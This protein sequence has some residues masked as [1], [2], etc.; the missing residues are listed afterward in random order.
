MPL[1]IILASTSPYRQQLLQNLGLKFTVEAPRISEESLKKQVVQDRVSPAD[2]AVQL[3]AAKAQSVA[4]IRSHALVIGSDQVASLGPTILDKSSSLEECRQQLHLLQGKTHRL[5]TAL[6]VRY[7][8]QRIEHLEICQLT[9][10]AL[11]STAIAAYVEK[12]RPIGCA[13]SY[14][15]ERSGIALFSTIECA[16]HSAIVG[17]PLIALSNILWKLGVRPFDGVEVD[18]E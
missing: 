7:R 10:R 15:L 17:L 9:M 2:L 5:S 3:A 4:E 11:N 18:H 6:S 13:G 12:E 8:D 14:K 1:E 16:D